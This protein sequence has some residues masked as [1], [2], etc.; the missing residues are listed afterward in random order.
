[1][2]KEERFNLIWIDVSGLNYNFEKGDQ[3]KA[4]LEGDIK[5]SYPAQAEAKKVK[6][7]DKLV[8]KVEEEKEGKA[9]KYKTFKE[10]PQN[11]EEPI[12]H[13]KELRG[14]GIIKRTENETIIYIG[15]GQKST[16][17][18]DITVESV[19]RLKDIIRIE[20]LEKTPGSNENVTQV[21]TYP[22]AVI[23]V[24][25]AISNIEVVND[26]G[27]KFENINDESL[28]AD[29]YEGK[30]DKL[31]WQE[32]KNSRFN[33]SI[34]FPTDWSKG[35]EAQNGDGI[36]LFP[37]NEEIDMRVYAS[38]Y[39]EGVS[40]PYKNA[41][42]RGFKK[43]TISLNGGKEAELITGREDEKVYFEMLYLT[44]EIEYHFIARTPKDFFK[45][46]ESKLKQVV[47]SFKV[48]G[49]V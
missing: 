21:I 30:N 24:F 44:D 10:L 31:N 12:E 19:R 37:E 28:E 33:Y 27:D 39:L 22:H 25:E 47:K 26:Q 7:I 6:V 23:K 45:K 49:E 41:K 43:S 20:V 9:L 48:K 4:W 11:L 5:E 1:M 2:T 17:G 14:F 8:S 34:K 15:S 36:T 42:K 13:V 29:Y 18:Y 32:Y 35:K 40:D 16:G 38:N 46:E 3:V